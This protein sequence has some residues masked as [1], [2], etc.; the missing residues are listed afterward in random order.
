MFDPANM[1]EHIGSDVQYTENLFDLREVEQY[2]TEKVKRLPIELSHDCTA[3][4]RTYYKTLNY[5]TYAGMFIIHP[6]CYASTVFQMYDAKADNLNSVGHLNWVFNNIQDKYVHNKPI[7]N[8]L[9]DFEAVA[10]LPGSNKFIEHVCPLKLKQICT[11]HRDKIVLKPHPISKDNVIEMAK[12]VIGLAQ[13]A[14][15]KSYL[16]DII[17]LADIVY[18]THISETAL[19]SLL[20]GKKI[21]PLDPFH[22]RLIGSFSHINHFCFTERDPLPVLD[23]IF[24]SEKSGVIHPEVDKDWKD[25]IDA[26]LD[27][28]LWN[29]ELAKGHYFD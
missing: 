27:Y 23:S 26:Y 2:L 29:R 10:V 28:T 12:E 14:S 3:D 1:L 11:T 4:E 15:D 20:M 5:T 16:Y 18:T 13:I 6:L 25:K 9:Q 22:N 17:D 21:S 7:E 19:T 24:A 8:A